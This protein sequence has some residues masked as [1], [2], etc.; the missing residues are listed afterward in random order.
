MP[1]FSL[2]TV[3]IINQKKT[4]HLFELIKI[5]LYELSSLWKFELFSHS[6]IMNT[7]YV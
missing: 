1:C 3:Y 4:I 7:V 5:V 2:Q 6:K